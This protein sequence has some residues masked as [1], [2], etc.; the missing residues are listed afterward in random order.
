MSHNKQHLKHNKKMAHHGEVVQDIIK[1]TGV[2][3]EDL[4]DKLKVNRRTIYHWIGKPYLKPAII[5]QIGQALNVDM[6]EA[7]PKVFGNV[8]HYDVS[9][10][11]EANIASLEG[12]DWKD[13]YIISTEQLLKC[14]DQLTEAVS[15]IA[16]LERQLAGGGAA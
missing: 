5:D 12:V 7:A 9:K 15:R 4:A 3:K 8:P 6:H 16:E 10:K 2:T 13:K 14:K 11:H 1:R